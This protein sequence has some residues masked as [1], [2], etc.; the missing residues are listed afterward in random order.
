MLKKKLIA[1][2]MVIYAGACLGASC[3][4]TI[5]API[6]F[7][8]YDPFSSS[9]SEVQGSLA[10]TCTDGSADY[11][12]MLSQGGGSSYSPRKMQTGGRSQKM[13]YNIYRE[14]ARATVWGDGTG[15]SYTVTGS[16]T[17][18]TAGDCTHYIYARIPAR[19]TDLFVG[20]YSDT[21]VATVTY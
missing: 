13:N 15:G 21:I 11:E 1:L 4:L 9:P 7:G 16:G 3:A 18:L 20:A 6:N 8:S 10:I 5:E 14:A 17:C 19:Q 12:I 2:L